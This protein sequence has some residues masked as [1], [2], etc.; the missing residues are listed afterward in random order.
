MFLRSKELSVPLF[1]EDTNYD[2]DIGKPQ[3]MLTKVAIINH[4][5]KV[6]AK[7]LV[8]GSQ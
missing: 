6:P 2:L 5:S 4:D 8:A 3:H 7:L 1:C